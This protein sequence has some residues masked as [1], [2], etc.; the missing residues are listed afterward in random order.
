MVYHKN[1]DK[2]RRRVDKPV[3][4]YPFVRIARTILD[5]IGKLIHS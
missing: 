1:H 3:I 2:K 5:T 4:I